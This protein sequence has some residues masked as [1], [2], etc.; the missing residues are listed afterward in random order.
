MGNDTLA[1]AFVA[2]VAALRFEN[3]FNP[4]SD[5]CPIHDRDDAAAVRTSNLVSVLTAAIDGGVHSLWIARDLGH[6]GGRRTGLALTDESNLDNH[7]SLL[8]SRPLQ[9]ATSTPLVSEITAR[10]VWERL[11]KV[12][13]RIFLWNV[14]PLHPHNAGDSLS[15]RKHSRLERETCAD[16]ILWLMAYLHPTE[17]VAIGGDAANALKRQKLIFKGVRHP[18]FG[19]QADFRRGVSRIY[20]LRS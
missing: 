9:K 17:I 3:V 13:R 1:K 8:G 5:I 10:V 2:Q 12:N 19:G 4:Y 16:L 20:R 11:L 15:N 7:A 6:K 18:S 14:F